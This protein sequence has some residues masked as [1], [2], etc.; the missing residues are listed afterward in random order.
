MSFIF[1]LTN[2]DSTIIG[3][4]L[5]FQTLLFIDLQNYTLP[6]LKLPTVRK[7]GTSNLVMKVSSKVSIKVCKYADKRTSGIEL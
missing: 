6:I 3:S 2:F 7:G 5:V 1:C 4:E